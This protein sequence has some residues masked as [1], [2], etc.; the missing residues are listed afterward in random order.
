MLNDACKSRAIYEGASGFFSSNSTLHLESFCQNGNGSNFCHR[1]HVTRLDHGKRIT[2]QGNTVNHK[3]N[4]CRL[5]AG[6]IEVDNLN[7][8]N[9]EER[10]LQSHAVSSKEWQM[11]KYT[12]VSMNFINCMRFCPTRD[13]GSLKIPFL[14][15]SNACP[16]RIFISKDTKFVRSIVCADKSVMNFSPKT[17]NAP[18]GSAESLAACVN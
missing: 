9:Q 15:L 18:H 12:Y 16:F 1:P 6:S 11:E 14:C 2:K 7:A 17:W 5:H 3:Q 8:P 4:P 13:P 10:L